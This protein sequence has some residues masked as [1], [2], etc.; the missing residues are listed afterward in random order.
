[1][2]IEL[3]HWQDWQGW[4]E[5][6]KGKADCGYGFRNAY[7]SC[8]YS[9]TKK[10]SNHCLGDRS[11]TQRCEIRQCEYHA[12]SELLNNFDKNQKKINIEDSYQ[13]MRNRIKELSPLEH[14]PIE[15]DSDIIKSIY[16]INDQD[17][18]Q[19]INCSQ[20]MTKNY[21]FFE[22]FEYLFLFLFFQLLCF[23]NKVY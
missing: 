7:R 10:K 21:H 9:N 1:L 2:N 11:K 6:Q 20:K 4:T 14:V 8:I 5:C 23:L 18:D 15:F 3:S 13:R 19:L 17:E 12:F 16:A 22:F